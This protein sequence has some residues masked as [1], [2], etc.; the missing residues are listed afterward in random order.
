MNPARVSGL[1]V[2]WSNCAKTSCEGV[3]LSMAVKFRHVQLLSWPATYTE[4]S[5]G[6]LPD[7]GAAHPEAA[8]RPA[9]CHC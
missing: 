6:I 2:L 5:A 4:A 9:Q 8:S 1:Q 7:G 3:H